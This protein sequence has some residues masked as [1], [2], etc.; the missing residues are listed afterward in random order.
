MPAASFT[1]TDPGV[2]D[3]TLV[4]EPVVDRFGIAPVVLPAGELRI[5]AGADCDIVLPHTG[6]ADRHG[7][8]ETSSTGTRVRALDPRTWLNNN[9]VDEAPVRRGDRLAIGPIEFRLRTAR[10]GEFRVDPVPA[11]AV[12]EPTAAEVEAERDAAFVD[13]L[14]EPEPTAEDARAALEDPVA[15]IDAAIE[16]ERERLVDAIQ[17]P[18]A[19][20]VKM[21]LRESSLRSLSCFLSE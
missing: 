21:A 4:L 2:S 5:G 12:P 13:R 1:S 19:P 16:T 15:Q 18:L 14:I 8:L 10:P 7:T 17:A 20:P 3:T 9:P 11:P 6:I